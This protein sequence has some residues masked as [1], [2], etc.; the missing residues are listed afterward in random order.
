MR[1]CVCAHTSVYTERDDPYVFRDLFVCQF[2]LL[3][4]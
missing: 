3:P 2:P 4:E 1:V